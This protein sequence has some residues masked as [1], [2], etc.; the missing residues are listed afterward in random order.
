MNHNNNYGSQNTDNNA[1]Q[2]AQA[3]I[4]KE[5]VAANQLNADETKED[6]DK[7]ATDP[8]AE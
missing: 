7:S 2:D 8:E 1:K 4:D 6:S 3:V 5:Q